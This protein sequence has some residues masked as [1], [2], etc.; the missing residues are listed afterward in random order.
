M[1]SKDGAMDDK[2][3]TT[4][5]VVNKKQ[6][7]MMNQEE[8]LPEEEYDRYRDEKMMRGGDH[9][10][11][12]TRE[13]SNTPTG[14]QPKGKTVMQKE[15]EKKYGKGKSALDMVKADHKDEIMDVNKKKKKKKD[16]KE[17]LDLTQVAES[18]GG[19]IIEIKIKGNK[20]GDITGVETTAA[21]KTA[22][23]KAQE[24]Q[25]EIFRK[26]AK[27]SG[28]QKVTK[29]GRVTLGGIKQGS[30]P[31]DAEFSQAAAQAQ[32]D[33]QT[34]TSPLGGKVEPDTKRAMRSAGRG[35]GGKQKLAD[36]TKGGEVKVI[37]Q[38]NPNVPIKKPTTANIKPGSIPEPK[39]TEFTSKVKKGVET[40]K[41]VV[42][43]T[44]G[45]PE[46]YLG[47]E[48]RTTAKGRAR[49]SKEIKDAARKAFPDAKNPPSDIGQ[50]RRQATRQKSLPLVQ[51]KTGVKVGAPTG[52]PAVRE[53]PKVSFKDLKKQIDVR[54]P[55]YVSP[56]SGGRLPVPK[57]ARGFAS[58]AAADAAAEASKKALT[59]K[60]TRKT[61][62]K[63]LRAGAGRLAAKR[64]PGIGLA[65]S[66]GEAGARAVSG[67][68]VGAAIAGA[69]GIASLIPGVGTLASM[70][71]GGYGVYR[72]A[73]RA[74]NVFKVAKRVRKAAKG[75]TAAQ[76]ASP[77]FEKGV[78]KKINKKFNP[79]SQL[80]KKV[81]KKR[82][83]MGAKTVL[84][85][86]VRTGSI[87]MGADMANKG[88]TALRVRKPKVDQGVVGRRTAG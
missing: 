21:E 70:G 41:G 88:L 65:I 2:K 19:Y 38:A 42:R 20:S 80:N 57:S 29:V 47:T 27:K 73:K 64:I 72:D 28:Q 85:T 14:K 11:K 17:E 45:K 59:K 4:K 67:D 62:G 63:T 33:I 68:Y 52:R 83:M 74:K 46:V 12:E 39:D 9:R 3:K 23:K 10:S 54:N 44:T 87:G 84:G 78:M 71:L 81:P 82:R 53:K 34:D 50:F 37:R 18:F 36:T 13:R 69:E 77:A 60:L 49:K 8:Y 40:K 15:L 56:K 61:M 75:K 25:K 43:G 32:R 55:T 24:K 31:S 16:T 7:Q 86:S 76:I 5:D 35:Q 79:I 1:P 58:P 51:T 48:T 6:K 26:A 66:A 22:A 30:L